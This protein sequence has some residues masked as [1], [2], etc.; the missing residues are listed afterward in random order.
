MSIES[1][2]FVSVLLNPSVSSKSF[3]LST[4][5]QQCLVILWKALD[6]PKI[7]NDDMY[8]SLKRF[9]WHYTHRLTNINY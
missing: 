9:T 8:L 7:L 3:L 1:L 4:S 6:G 5:G 2:R